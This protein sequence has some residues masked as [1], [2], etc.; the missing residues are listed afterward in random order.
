V[1][2]AA[3]G[4]TK[5]R[6]KDMLGFVD[7][8][9]AARPVHADPPPPPVA[10]VPPPPPP[11]VPMPLSPVVPM[12]PPP[13]AAAPAPPIAMPAAAWPP[14]AAKQRPMPDEDPDDL[15][16]PEVEVTEI[17]EVAPEVGPSRATR[18]TAPTLA[19]REVLSMAGLV[20]EL[21]VPAQR[22]AIVRAA[23][24][25]L[26][27]Q[28]DTPPVHWASIRQALSFMLD[29]PQIARRVLP[30]LMPYLEEAA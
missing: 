1:P 16:E 4:R 27:R 19:A 21:G 6:L 9:A 10:A 23:L 28:M 8:P 5:A 22:R 18:R 11:V 2:K 24:I 13:V 15:E 12:P 7:E 20:A 3:G 26:G 29:Y 14:P 30:L 17:E 25:D